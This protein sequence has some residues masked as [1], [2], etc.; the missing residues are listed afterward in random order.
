MTPE[1]KI[2][3]KALNLVSDWKK[4]QHPVVNNDNIDEIYEDFSQNDNFHGC[5]I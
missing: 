1:Q 3:W 4:V 2:K 5:I